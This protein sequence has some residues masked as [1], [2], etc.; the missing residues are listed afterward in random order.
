MRP[1]NFTSNNNNLKSSFK[2]HY[3]KVVVNKTGAYRLL[4]IGF[5][6]YFFLLVFEGALRRWFL[7]GLAAPLLIIRDP[8]ALWLLLSCWYYRVLKV[9]IYLGGMVLIG[10]IGSFTAIFFGHGSIPVALFGARILLIQF[11]LIFV[12]GR[13]FTREDVLKLGKI[14]LWICLPMTILIGLQF[15]S[16]QSAWVNRGLGGVYEEKGFQGALGHFR[17]PGTF[18]YV[19]GT[20]LFYGLAIC[21]I[22]YYWLSSN[23]ISKVLLI[24]STLCII[25][26]IPLS[27]SRTLFFEV[28]VSLV[29]AFFGVL[30]KPRYLTRLLYTCIIIFIALLILSRTSFFHHATD[31]FFARFTDASASEGGLKGTL[32]DRFFGGLINAIT[33]ASEL[34]FFGYGIGLGTNVGSQL[35]AGSRMFLLH[36]EEWSRVMDELGPVLGLSVTFLRLSLIIKIAKACFRKL[37]KGDMLPWLLLSFGFLQIA[38]GNWSQPTSLGFCTLIGG[39]IIAS[40]RANAYMHKV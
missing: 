32:G 20:Y 22:I 5:W 35:M 7:P 39:L 34:P 18:S 33:G 23:N 40:L 36:E 9:N 11:P 16:P 2:P 3:R 31:T 28:C 15:F 37:Q 13:I 12:I 29:F 25:I 30:K 27:I 8:L 6:I 10:F 14:I 4:K 26:A 17:P 19:T 1:I 24:A 21:Y 38:Q